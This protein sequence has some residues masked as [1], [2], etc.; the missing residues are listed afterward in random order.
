MPAAVRH[1]Q[2]RFAGNRSL[3]RA[4]ATDRSWRPRRQ[5][6]CR[7]SV[8]PD[9]GPR[10]SASA[11]PGNLR[12]VLVDRDLDRGAVVNKSSSRPPASPLRLSITIEASG[13]FAAEIRGGDPV[14]IA[15]ATRAA[16][17]SFNSTAMI[18]EVSMTISMAAYSH[19]SRGSRRPAGCRDQARP[20]SACRFRGFRRRGF[21]RLARAVPAA[22]VPRRLCEPRS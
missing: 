22:G 21:G 14:S 8:R 3:D 2:Y 15:C 17:A 9:A 7:N 16:V 10:Q 6:N 18:A 19:R 13:R 20:R 1:L 5:S 11:E 12:L 4:A